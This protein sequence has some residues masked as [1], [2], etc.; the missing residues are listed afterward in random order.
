MAR[1]TIQIYEIQTPEEAG[2]MVDQGV[3]RI[4]SVLLSEVEGRNPEI[5]ETIRTAAEA[6]ARSSLIPLFSRPDPVFRALDY[7]RPDMVHFCEALVDGQGRRRDV[8]PLLRLQE[9]VRE[10]FPEIRI[11]RSIPIAPPGGGGRIDS[12]GLA[13]TFEP[14]SDVFLTDTLILD[15]P[16]SAA[17]DQP[18][19]GFVGITGRVCDWGVARDLVAASRIPVILAGG[20]D[21]ENVAEGVAAVRPAGVDSCTGTNARDGRGRPIRFKKDPDRVRRLVEE[22]RR[23]GDLL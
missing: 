8:S 12:L 10:R 6:G 20:I 7:H 3:D 15:P 13:R 22:T 5:R 19:P 21:P 17:G 14:M 9:A 4:G 1:L 16:A 23:A 2:E 11:M 18:V